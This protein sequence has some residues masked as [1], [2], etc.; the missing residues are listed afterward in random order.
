MTLLRRNC[1]VQKLTAQ[2]VFV[3]QL[4][5]RQDRSS[6]NVFLEIPY[7][8][9]PH[10]NAGNNEKSKCEPYFSTLFSA[11]EIAKGLSQSVVI[12]SKQNFRASVCTAMASTGII[13][14]MP[15]SSDHQGFT[16]H[17]ICQ[18]VIFCDCCLLPLWNSALQHD[19]ATC[20]GRLVNPRW[21]NLQ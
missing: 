21:P 12:C 9:S 20:R 4:L 14:P 3:S 5:P 7:R 13:G 10:L 15:T 16:I 6:E 2:N 19:G 18:C 17:K 8:S 1:G 11:R